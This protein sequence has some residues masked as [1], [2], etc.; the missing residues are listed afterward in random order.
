MSGSPS[1][2][3]QFRP[4]VGLLLFLLSVLVPLSAFAQDPGPLPEASDHVLDHAQAQQP[5]APVERRDAPTPV[6]YDKS[7]F[8][9]PLDPAQLTALRSFGGAPA[10][11]LFHDKQFRKLMKAFVPNCMFHYGRDMPLDDALD[12]ALS[13]SQIP[14]Q[15]H[16]DRYVLLSGN[17]GPYLSGRAFLWIDT[18]DGI[19]LG[20]F[21]FTPTNGEP[22]PSLAVFSR[23]VKEAT[24]ALSQLPPAFAQDL[25][26][27]SMRAGIP[28][29]T[30]R[31]FLNGANKRI[32][33]EHDEDFCSLGDGTAAPPDSGCEQLNA[34]AADTDE[35]AAYYLDQVH[36]ATNATA[37]MLGPDQIAWVQL[38]DRT[39]LG[40][41]DP[42]GCRIRLTRERTHGIIHRPPIHPGPHPH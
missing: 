36:Y 23:Q 35:T 18:V 12:M 32:L 6:P 20:A 1:I 17:G 39:C 38:R 14:V 11:D 21:F 8:L 34:D 41:A 27:W 13:N 4:L 31:Y 40:I 33:L 19:G 3:R 24:L 37:W 16:D 2:N 30:T 26:L 9:T 29:I 5:P 25:T 7:I 15:V 22:T 28:S 42:L 10:R